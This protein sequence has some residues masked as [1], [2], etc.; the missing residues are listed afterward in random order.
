MAK[1]VG[2]RLLKPGLDP[3]P[4]GPTVFSRRASSAS[5]ETS[6]RDMA[7]ADSRVLP[8]H[9]DPAFETL[10]RKMVSELLRSRQKPRSS[11]SDE[12]S[13]TS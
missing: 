7:E 6:P 12:S 13:E 10:H 9:D 11:A 2:E 8:A 5:S 3:L 4:I 1:I